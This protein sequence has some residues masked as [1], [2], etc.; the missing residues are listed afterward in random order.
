M[1]ASEQAAQTSAHAPVVCRTDAG[2]RVLAAAHNRECVP[3]RL[4]EGFRMLPSLNYGDGSHE[5][6]EDYD[7]FYCSRCGL[8]GFRTDRGKGTSRKTGK[9]GVVV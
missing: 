5:G 9:G 4:G 3:T 1:T 6:E 8:D 7:Y 2:A